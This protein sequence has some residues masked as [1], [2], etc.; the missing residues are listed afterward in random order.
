M[1]RISDG[2]V[3]PCP[4]VR[5][6]QAQTS[7]NISVHHDLVKPV[8]NLGPLL[9]LPVILFSVVTQTTAFSQTIPSWTIAF[10]V[11]ALALGTPHGAVDDLVLTRKTPVKTLIKL[12]IIYTS[13]ATLAASAILWK[14][15]TM[16]LA[17]LVMTIWH[18]GTGDVEAA[19]ELIGLKVSR[20]FKYWIHVIAAGSVPVMLPLTSPAAISTLNSIQ[21]KLAQAFSPSTTSNVRTAVLVVA[22]V[23]LIF[24]LLD[25]NTRGA[26][27]LSALIALGLVV[28]PLLAFATYFTFWHATRHTARLALSAHGKVTRASIT[29]V[30][31]HGLP[32]LVAVSAVLIWLLT[33]DSL[34]SSM[35]QWLWLGLAI[36]WGL[37]VP[38]MIAVAYFDRNSRNRLRL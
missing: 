11:I 37:T 34:L 30:F 4:K 27:E 32:A 29:K 21:P 2:F 9:I 36:T 15:A 16:F 14:P 10:A 26:I 23:S 31:V 3:M 20:G 17:V 1:F 5:V 8:M 28:A 12:A 22:L 35:H 6:M 13:I 33:R 24:H 19:S 7:R 18:F 38:H 25:S